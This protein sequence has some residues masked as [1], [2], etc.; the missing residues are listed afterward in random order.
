ML[1][2]SPLGK[3][4]NKEAYIKQ[5]VWEAAHLNNEK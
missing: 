1:R 5:M 3:I 2:L 4:K